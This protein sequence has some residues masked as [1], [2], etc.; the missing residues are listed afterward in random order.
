MSAMKNR[1]CGRGIYTLMLG[2]LLMGILSAVLTLEG[3][4]FGRAQL[5]DKNEFY[6]ALIELIKEGASTATLSITFDPAQINMDEFEERAKVEGEYFAANIPSF[7]FKETKT[8]S[9]YDIEIL[10]GSIYNP[11]V[12]QEKKLDVVV[13]G[14]VKECQ[15]MSD[16]EKIKYVHDYLVLNCE[17][18]G[19]ADGAY[20]ALCNKRACCNGYARGFLRVMEAMDIP[21]KYTTNYE[22]AWN[23]V[24]LDGK[25]YNLDATWDDL[26]GDGISYEYFLKSNA[27]W[28]GE[29]PAMATAASSYPLSGLDKKYEY[30]DFMLRANIRLAIITLVSGTVLILLFR[31][32]KNLRNNKAETRYQNN[33]QKINSLYTVDRSNEYVSPYENTGEVRRDNWDRH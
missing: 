21:C 18:E 7:Q 11:T 8:G 27:E 6:E 17:Y 4:A 2:F 20:Q 24:Y 32:M 25:W 3:S 26:G 28:G 9:G 19:T 16:Y 29:G 14:I 31:F 5:K 10:M 30:P 12:F 22:H 1:I 33:M 15:G 13:D 23:T